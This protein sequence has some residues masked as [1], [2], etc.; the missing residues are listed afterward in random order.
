MEV[1]K[2]AQVAARPLSSQI[3]AALR[4]SI[5]EGKMPPGTQLRE[6]HLAEQF[7]VSQNTVRE[8]LVELQ[9]M[10]LVQ[11]LPNRATHVTKL[12]HE[13]ILERI[14][15]RIPLERTACAAA[16]RSAGAADFAEL[17]RRL[18]AITHAIRVNDYA[19]CAS[20]DLDFHRYIWS[21][22]GNRT[23]YR[24]LDQVTAPLFAF[25]N[26]MEH[27]R[28]VVLAE[29]ANSH[30]PILQ[31]LRSADPGA[32]ERS[33]QEHVEGSYERILRWQARERSQSSCL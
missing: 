20:A 19:G 24:I 25:L 28:S 26:I 21:L 3:Y 17:E 4:Q 27:D 22:S 10:G 12:S 32:A 6:Q 31:A 2:F 8:A 15:V 18:F 11:R 30:D 29:V 23:L 33:I 1:E 7:G 13:E 14:H 9:H 16:T 5:F